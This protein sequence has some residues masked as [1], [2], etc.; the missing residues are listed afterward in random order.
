MWNDI[1]YNE[2]A[3]I[4]K[5]IGEY[6][7]WE[8]EKS[9]FGKF[10]IKIYLDFNGFYSGYTNIQV[11]D[12]TGSYYCA[13]GHGT[14]E[15]MALRDTISEYLRLVSWKQDWEASDFLWSEASDF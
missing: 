7:I 10:K 2:I 11:I 13:V 14:T 1:T 3:K 8:L 6:N 9:P 4:E 5:L 12:K 15:E